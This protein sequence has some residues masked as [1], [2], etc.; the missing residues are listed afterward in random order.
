MYMPVKSAHDSKCEVNDRGAIA[1][2]RPAALLV[3]TIVAEPSASAAQSIAPSH[4]RERA[5][6]LGVNE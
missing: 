4:D 1:A 5:R 3:C 2:D 6:G